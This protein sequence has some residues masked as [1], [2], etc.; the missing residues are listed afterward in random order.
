MNPF[1]IFALLG[2]AAFAAVKGFGG[3]GGG[4]GTGVITRGNAWALPDVDSA[5]QAGGFAQTHDESFEKASGEAGVPF[6][7]IK[8]HA[9]RESSLDPQATSTTDDYG[10]MQVNWHPGSDRFA[11]YGFP[12]STLGDGG[13]QLLDPDTCSLIGAYIIRDNLNWLNGAHTMQGLRDTINA[14]NIGTTEA[15]APAPK[16][17]VNDVLGYYGKILGQSVTV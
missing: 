10:I 4:G 14:Y 9:I 6:A 1:L 3:G 16:N 5:N 2:V 7:L 8:A 12:D 15:K 13:E 11:K 17:Y